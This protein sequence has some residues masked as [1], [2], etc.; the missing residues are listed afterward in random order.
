MSLLVGWLVNA[1]VIM[2]AAYVLPGI[3]VTSFVSALIAAVVMAFVNTFVKPVLVILT[4]P[5]TLL[6]LGLFLLVLN[7]LL[8]L[9]V[10]RLVPGFE[11]DGFWPALLLSIVLWLVNSVLHQLQ[12]RSDEG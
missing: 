4:F 7:A 10:S 6:T 8:V 3:N 2:A 11:V 5:I 1:L 9:L 12:S